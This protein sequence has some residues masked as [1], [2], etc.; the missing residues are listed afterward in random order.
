MKIILTTFLIL[1]VA[2]TASNADNT[3][4]V[5]VPSLVRNRQLWPK[6]V[7]L[8]EKVSFPII[9][10][11]Q[12][13]GEA[14]VP[15]GIKLKL[16][17]VRGDFVKLAYGEVTQLVPATNTDLAARIIE[18][19]SAQ[20]R[21]AQYRE[22]AAIH[23]AQASTGQ[24]IPSQVIAAGGGKTQK[25]VKIKFS[26]VGGIQ[27]GAA[28]RF[29]TTLGGECVEFDSR[30]KAFLEEKQRSHASWEKQQ[31]RYEKEL[32]AGSKIEVVKRLENYQKGSI[33]GYRPVVKDVKVIE[34]KQPPPEPV[35]TVYGV[36]GESGC[37]NLIGSGEITGMNHEM[38]YSW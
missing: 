38:R 36:Q 28:G 2:I 26:T 18:V 37:M 5:D 30:G 4:A 33:I 17:D 27:T 14:E 35:F 34:P 16:V 10:D 25:V 9:I 8:T 7:T 32:A 1:V 24:D 15:A 12:E 11:G 6:E 13:K 19:R 21:L 3:N 29:V 23:M 31:E 22:Q 20:G